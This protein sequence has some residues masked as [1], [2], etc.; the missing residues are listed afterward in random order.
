MAQAESSDRKRRSFI[1]SV[2]MIGLISLVQPGCNC[3]SSGNVEPA[4]VAS[5][6]PLQGSDTA[7]VNT[8]VVAFFGIDMNGPSVESS[9][10]LSESGG[11]EQPAAVIYDATTRSAILDPIT[12]LKSGTEYRATISS[13][14]QDAAGNTPL[15]SDFV[16]S[17]TV[18]PSMLLVSR[19][20]T[21]VT[22]NNTSKVADIDAEGRYIVFESTAT[23]LVSNISTGG[24]NQIYRKDTLTGEVLLVSSD[25]TG[26]VAADIASS[27]PRI[28]SN[29]RFVVFESKSTNLDPLIN[30][31][32]I[33][34]IYIKDMDTGSIEIASR[35]ISL[36][37]DNSTNTAANA[38]VSDNGRFVVFQSADND[39]SSTIGQAGIIQIYLKDLSDESV[40]MISRTLTVTGNDDSTNPDMSPDGSFIVFESNATNLALTTNFSHIYYV[41]STI[42]HAV[43][44]VSV[45]TDGLTG[46]DA[47]S[48]NPSISDDGTRV[49]FQSDATNLDGFDTNGTTDIYRRDR[50]TPLTKLVSANPVTLSSGDGASTRP[51]LNGTG[52]FVVFESN[53]N[54]LDGGN[55]GVIDIFVSDLSVSPVIEIVRVNIPASGSASTSDSNSPVISSDGRYVSFDS[56]ESYTLDGTDIFLDVYRALNSTF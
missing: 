1:A 14:V 49:V 47:N 51:D 5:V 25:S 26:F 20:S 50:L 7:L 29:G 18:S 12:D 45:T 9:F 44:Q 3:G 43:E 38:R 34:Q 53:A 4:P 16:W 27:N 24:I 11:T 15:A 36:A 8:N 19:N 40:D 17:F 32:G 30:S 21:G 42:T 13:T 35:S 55:V 56:V 46:A 54:D 52:N 37:P 23:N 33:A 48:F 39:L 28:S 10:T 31:N 22:A 6:F 2:L 41:N